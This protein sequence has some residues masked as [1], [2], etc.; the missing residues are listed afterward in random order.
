MRELGDVSEEQHRLVGRR[1]AEVADQLIT[2]GTLA[3]TI[4]EVAFDAAR[5]A[6]RTLA[7]STFELDQREQI[8]AYLRTELRDGDVALLKGSRG[9][10][11]EDFVA[12]LRTDSD[13]SPE[14]AA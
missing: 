3:K 1:A 5:A 7:V 14:S 13:A 6:G 11:M 2:F 10:K 8:V 9:L 12:A 4:A